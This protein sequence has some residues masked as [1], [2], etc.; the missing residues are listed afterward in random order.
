MPWP[1]GRPKTE[2][3]KARVKKT[4]LEQRGL[5][6]KKCLFCEQSFKPQYSSQ[7]Y[8]TRLC[9]NR[10]NPPPKGIPIQQ[11]MTREA[12]E[13]NR[14]SHIG[15]HYPAEV[16]KRKGRP[17]ARLGR[18]HTEETRKLMS[19]RARE[20]GENPEYVSKLL[21]RLQIKP[22]KIEK[23][24]DSI[25]QKYFPSQW[26]Y[27]GDGTLMIG[28]YNPDFANCNGKKQL[29]EVY[30]EYWHSSKNKRLTWD[31]TEL[32]RMM[33][34]NS[35]GFRCLILWESEVKNEE[36]VVARVKQFMEGK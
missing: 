31:K 17:Q 30:G 18:K 32:G 27:V 34:Y 4:L 2:E 19:Q 33:A 1:K 9:A 24:L 13:K 21:A 20:R 12:R 29:I 6:S 8:C 11:C 36:A 26:K 22:T 16:N 35:L 3:F 25:L 28:R 14:L 7:I 15:I 10:A 23:Q 5:P